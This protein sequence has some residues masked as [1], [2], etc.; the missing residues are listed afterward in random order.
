MNE[1]SESNKLLW[2]GALLVLALTFA[3]HVHG[4]RGQFV[5]WDD[6]NHITRNV[7]IRALTLENLGLMFAHPIAKLYCPLTWL[8]F[9]IDYQIWGRD[10]FGY[11]FTNLLLHVAN[12]LLVMMLVYELL[13][14][15][16][17]QATIIAALT[18]AL[19]G[20]HPLRVESVAWATERKDVLY[21]LFYLLS[22]IAYLRWTT[23]RK[24]AAYWCCFGFFVVA[25]LS[26]SAA[27][28]LPVVLLLVDVFWSRRAALA[29][30][31]PFF[32]VSAIIAAATFV[33]QAGGAGHT[34]AG[35][36]VIP[37][38]AR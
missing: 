22:L 33:A 12:T 38:V 16:S 3:A 20:V 37:L 4:L 8:S 15:R 6:T 10:P 14:D 27:V 32:A 36:E 34:V 25:A 30:K 13:K 23:T 19:F 7:A 31:I 5:E 29:E 24:S 11:H 18:A 2:V 9:A 21:A 17:P 28:T 26:K 35:T 1:Q